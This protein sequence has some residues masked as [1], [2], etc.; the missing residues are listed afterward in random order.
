[1][2][3]TGWLV[4]VVMFLMLASESEGMFIVVVGALIWWIVRE[5]RRRDRIP[6]LKRMIEDLFIER[7]DN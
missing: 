6:D 1:M 3:G 4:L 7:D 5:Y 2:K